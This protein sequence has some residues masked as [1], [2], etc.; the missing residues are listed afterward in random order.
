MHRFGHHWMYGPPGGNGFFWWPGTLLSVL[1][2][3]FWLALLF[4]LIWAIV[5][6]LMPSIRPMLKSVFGT[7]FADASALEILRQRYAAG[8]IDSLTFERM[9]ERL[10]VSYRQ[11][12]PGLPHDVGY[13]EGTVNCSPIY[14]VENERIRGHS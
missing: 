6:L 5:S 1:L 11:E 8:E 12:G 4:G 7:K 9:H 2:V 10:M 14:V 3:L 13:Q